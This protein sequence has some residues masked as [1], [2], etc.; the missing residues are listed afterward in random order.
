MQ[1]F[2]YLTD[3]LSSYKMFRKLL[4][5]FQMHLACTFGIHPLILLSLYFR[6]IQSVLR[7]K[8]KQKKLKNQKH[9]TLETL[10][11]TEYYLFQMHEEVTPLIS[12]VLHT[13]S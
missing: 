4:V 11:S 6:A 9:E 10:I 8:T 2:C 3:L 5:P 12:S 1:I 13:L 7:P